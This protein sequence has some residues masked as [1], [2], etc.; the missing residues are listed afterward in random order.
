MGKDFLI[1]SVLIVH[2][3]LSSCF[4]RTSSATKNNDDSLKVCKENI[5]TSIIDESEYIDKQWDTTGMRFLTD[6]IDDIHMPEVIVDT[7]MK[8]FRIRYKILY[9]DQLVPCYDTLLPDRS[10]FMDI[11]YKKRPILY[12]EYRVSD[13]PEIISAE[14]SA[15]HALSGIYTISASDSTASFIMGYHVPDTDLGYLV[16]LTV[17]KDGEVSTT[18]VYWGEPGDSDIENSDTCSM[19]HA[20]DEVLAN[21]IQWD[22]TGMRFLT[23]NI[24]DHFWP[25]T[26][27]DTAINNFRIR[28]K[29]LYNDQLVPCHDTLLPNRSVFLNVQYNKNLLLNREFRVTDFSDIIPVAESGKYQLSGMIQPESI[30]DSTVS[31]RLGYYIPDTD[32][33]YPIMLTVTKEGKVLTSLIDEGE[34]GE[35]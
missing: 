11:Q 10:I 26:V 19:H 1:A 34:L 8:D 23:D 16:M 27:V 13:F 25:E 35:D 9:N 24:D 3:I 18:E 2:C 12:K 7:M 31:F 32:L 29:V 28:Y 33:G 15:K 30:S 6:N 22:S 21:D 14:E 4:N 20:H 17:T 5:S